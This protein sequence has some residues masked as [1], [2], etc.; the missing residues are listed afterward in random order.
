MQQSWCWLVWQ[1]Q[2]KESIHV[3]E[4]NACICLFVATHRHRPG[5][6]WMHQLPEVKKT[7]EDKWH[8]YACVGDSFITRKDNNFSAFI[9]HLSTNR[10]LVPLG[11]WCI[12]SWILFFKRWKE[13]H[14]LLTPRWIW[15]FSFFELYTIFPFQCDQF[16]SRLKRPL[17]DDNPI[18]FLSFLSNQI[19]FQLSFEPKRR[20]KD[21]PLTQLVVDRLVAIGHDCST[22]EQA[23]VC[24]NVYGFKLIN[25]MVFL[26][27][28]N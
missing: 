15:R 8:T 2:S 10:L 11:C 28:F 6:H 19:H 22:E 7:T 5:L 27:V 16:V 1:H 26:F 20:L 9:S 21:F 13:T 12:T 23:M 25:T 14:L 4:C 18:F 3:F 24:G 17:W